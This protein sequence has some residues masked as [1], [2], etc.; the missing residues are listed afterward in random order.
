MRFFSVVALTSCFF[1]TGFV[2]ATFLE[3]P[4]STVSVFSSFVVA[5]CTYF[6][7][8]EARRTREAQTAPDVSVSFTQ[9]NKKGLIYIVVKNDGAG[10]A[11]GIQFSVDGNHQT[12]VRKVPLNETYFVKDGINYLVP[13]QEFRVLFNHDMAM[14]PKS[15]ELEALKMTVRYENDSGKKY[16]KEFITDFSILRDTII[17]DSKGDRCA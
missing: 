3:T 16:A 2:L 4:V 15:G 17:E 9:P 5:I 1:S 8:D 6:L 14:L 12:I 13:K 11:R 10:T 7:V